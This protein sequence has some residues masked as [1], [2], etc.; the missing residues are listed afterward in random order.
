MTISLLPLS[1][2]VLQWQHLCAYRQDVSS[3]A[4]QAEN[5][6]LNQHLAISLADTNEQIK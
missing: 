3:Q 5:C 6:A 4:V 1:V 2:Q